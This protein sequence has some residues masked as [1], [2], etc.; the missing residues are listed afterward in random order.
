MEIVEATR[1]GIGCGAL[2]CF[3]GE[4]YPDLH[5]VLNGKLEHVREIWLVTHSEISSSARIRTVYDFLG[6]ALEED[7]DSLIG[8]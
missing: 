7:G 8:Q 1:A 6:K 4:Q 3:V 5:R 2:C